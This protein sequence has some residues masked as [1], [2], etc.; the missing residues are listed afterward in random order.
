MTEEQF[1]RLVETGALDQPS[2]RWWLWARGVPVAK[3]PTPEVRVS[4]LLEL[5]RGD[6][7]AGSEHVVLAAAIARGWCPELEAAA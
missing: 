3:P 4:A 1:D 5:S 7:D 6:T 2:V